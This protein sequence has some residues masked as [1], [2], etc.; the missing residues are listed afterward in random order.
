MPRPA[1]YVP[2]IDRFVVKA[3]H[4]E[5]RHRRMPMTRLVD[6]LLRDAL[7]GGTGWRLAEAETGNGAGP[8]SVPGNPDAG[9]A[10]RYE[11]A[12]EAA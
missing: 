10:L 9:T 4:H 11:A 6:Q 3:L 1:H 12:S 7:C 8:E 5:A 2:A